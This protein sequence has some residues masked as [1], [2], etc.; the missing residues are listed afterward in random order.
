MEF[1]KDV[2]AKHKKY[3]YINV[4]MIFFKIDVKTIL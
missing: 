1:V 3:N 2:G 4:Y